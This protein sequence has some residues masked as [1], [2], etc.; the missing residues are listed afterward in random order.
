MALS[1]LEPELEVDG[2]EHSRTRDAM[3][4]SIQMAAPCALTALLRHHSNI[5]FVCNRF[6][7]CSQ[8]QF[9]DVLMQ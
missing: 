2:S 1:M 3:K 9:R 4:Y 7:S 6:T 8:Q 5:K